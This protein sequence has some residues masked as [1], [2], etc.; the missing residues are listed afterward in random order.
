MIDHHLN[1]YVSRVICHPFQL[2]LLRFHSSNLLCSLSLD[3]V[4]F[5]EQEADQYKI[6]LN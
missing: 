6:M 5:V 2:L 1:R 4:R 3:L